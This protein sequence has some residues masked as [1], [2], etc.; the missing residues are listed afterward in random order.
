MRAKQFLGSGQKMNIKVNGELM[1]KLG[2]GQRLIIKTPVA[3]SIRIDIMSYSEKDVSIIIY[4]NDEQHIYLDASF[5]VS[6]LVINIPVGPVSISAGDHSEGFESGIRVERLDN[7]T[8]QA[9][10]FKSNLYKTSPDK[11]KTIEL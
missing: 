10:F 6:G 11:L 8:G 4:P 5:R 9:L 7:E 3:D 2:N 1:H